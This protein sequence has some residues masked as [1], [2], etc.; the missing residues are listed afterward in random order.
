MSLSFF[1]RTKLKIS[2]I[3]QL[4]TRK[5]H[6]RTTRHFCPNS[7]N[8][9]DVDG[10]SPSMPNPKDRATQ[11]TNRVLQRRGI[12]AGI[13][14]RQLTHEISNLVGPSPTDFATQ[15]H[16]TRPAAPWAGQLWMS[17]LLLVSRLLQ[18]SSIVVSTLATC[19]FDN[20]HQSCI[21][22]QLLGKPSTTTSIFLLSN[23]PGRKRSR[24]ATRTL[25]ESHPLASYK[26][27]RH[28]HSCPPTTCRR[29]HRQER[30]E[31]G[32]GHQENDEATEP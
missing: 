9:A 8:T 15:H 21:N 10:V 24:S 2:C 31:R 23:L 3:Q 30:A 6:T 11:Q 4:F 28:H 19:P 22:C 1:F 32:I 13:R 16:Q 17:G 12:T 27:G 29:P 14:L 7:S 26:C 25:T 20:R 18:N 5:V